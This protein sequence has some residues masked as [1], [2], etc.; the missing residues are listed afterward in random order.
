MLCVLKPVLCFETLFVAE[1]GVN[2][3]Y[4]QSIGVKDLQT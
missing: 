4:K 1:E 2:N 3:F